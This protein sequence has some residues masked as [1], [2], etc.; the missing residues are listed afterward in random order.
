MRRRGWWT[1]PVGIGL[2]RNEER[3]YKIVWKGSGSREEEKRLAE[4]EEEER[5]QERLEGVVRRE[6][7]AGGVLDSWWCNEPAA[8]VSTP[9]MSTS[10]LAGHGPVAGLGAVIIKDTIKDPKAERCRTNFTMIQ[11]HLRAIQIGASTEN[12]PLCYQAE[13]HTS[14]YIFCIIYFRI[15]IKERL[16]L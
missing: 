15:L 11:Q 16:V 5:E 1:S 7:R 9:P 6:E 8:T 3:K 12:K 10:T 14:I 13:C 2:R 4:V